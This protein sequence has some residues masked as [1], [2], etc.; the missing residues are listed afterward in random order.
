ML[1]LPKSQKN[2]FGPKAITLYISV[3]HYYPCAQC[4]YI[5]CLAHIS[6][7]TAKKS[8]VGPCT[9]WELA[10][11]RIK[12]LQGRQILWISR[13]KQNTPKEVITSLWR[14]PTDGCS[15]LMHYKWRNFNRTQTCVTTSLCSSFTAE[16]SLGRSENHFTFLLTLEA[17]MSLHQT[18]IPAYLKSNIIL[19]KKTNITSLSEYSLV[20]LITIAGQTW[21]TWNN[22]GA[23]QGLSLSTLVQLLSPHSLTDWH[24]APK[25]WGCTSLVS[26]LTM[27]SPCPVHPWLHLCTSATPKDNTTVVR[28]NSE[29]ADSR[30]QEEENLHSAFLQWGL[31]HW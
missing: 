25:G 1:G 11:C 12:V 26:S 10:F 18:P 28:L 24:S 31:R 23:M 3:I 17:N 21:A 27:G 15:K 13:Q 30:P 22:K 2:Q 9:G 19:P 5:A 4:W 8:E 20:A 16:R 14:L 29:G 6:V 7:A